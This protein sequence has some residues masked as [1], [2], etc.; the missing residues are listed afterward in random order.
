MF[1]TVE[2]DIL[3]QLLAF[4]CQSKC[5]RGKML[6]HSMK[7][8]QWNLTWTVILQLCTWPVSRI[9]SFGGRPASFQ[10]MQEAVISK[11]RYVSKKLFYLQHCFPFLPP[12]N[13]IASSRQCNPPVKCQ[14]PQA[15]YNFFSLTIKK[16]LQDFFFLLNLTITLSFRR[17]NSQHK[18]WL[19]FLQQQYW[20][21][22]QNIFVSS[23]FCTAKGGMSILVIIPLINHT[24]VW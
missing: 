8:I 23:R 19:D 2:Q 13:N 3:V 1:C 15:E 16:S 6:G 10:R 4:V 21:Y 9:I 5:Y 24:Q 17:Y 22:K 18:Y 12:K 11:I 14:Y 20:I 7:E